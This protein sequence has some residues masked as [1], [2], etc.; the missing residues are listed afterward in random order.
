MKRITVI[1]CGDISGIYLK[2]LT[3]IFS[4]RLEIAGVYDVVPEK[5]GNRAKEF[6]VKKVYASLDEALADPAADIIL[7][8]TRPFEHFA[9]TEAAL[10]AGKHVYSEKPL[11]AD[12]AE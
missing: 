4:D 7:N 5:S 12:L 6:G 10:N 3:G 1:G 8:L 9:V 11:G 2:N